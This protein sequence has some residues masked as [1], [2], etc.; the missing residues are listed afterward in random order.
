MKK[1]ILA[2]AGMAA[3][4]IF[5]MSLTSFAAE[6]PKWIV[7]KGLSAGEYQSMYGTSDWY[8]CE[9][10]AQCQA[11]AEA[12]KGDIIGIQDEMTRYTAIVNKVCS[13]LTYDITYVQPHIAYTIRDGKGV[14]ADYTALTLALCE[15][16]GIK[17]VVSGGVLNGV[18]HDMLKVT[19]NG[20]EYYSDLTNYDSGVVG[21]LGMT[22]G[23][24]EDSCGG[25][26]VTANYSTGADTSANSYTVLCME[27]NKVG[28]VPIV[29]KNGTY[30]ITKADG[31]LFDK[32]A[33][34]G[35]VSGMYS[36][37]DKYNIPH[38]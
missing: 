30:Y 20:V 6:E 5:G 21:V 22:P 8:V 23:Y 27:A 13:F 35:D 19:I 26:L 25:G 17:A 4:M 12:N 15:K 37:L 14:C 29:N 16:C 1:R 10:V 9:G 3:T 24:R 34:A 7:P 11:W 33:E 28:M 36:I 38:A 2:L 32:Y 18:E 31:E